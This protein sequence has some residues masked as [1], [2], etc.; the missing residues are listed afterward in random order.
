MDAEN[1]G[2]ENFTLKS[3]QE[4]NKFSFEVPS[5]QRGYRW[6]E[7][8][9]QELLDDLSDFA[10]SAEKTYLLQPLVVCEVV[11]EGKEV[12][13]VLDGQQRLTTLYLLLTK[14]GIAHYSLS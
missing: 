9:V 1:K 6:G 7:L 8:Q 5:F 3:V 4:L 14:L 13:R 11:Q 2:A 12:F 10:D